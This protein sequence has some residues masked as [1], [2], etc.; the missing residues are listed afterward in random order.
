MPTPT[1][2]QVLA[3]LSAV[4]D[5]EIHQ[6]ITDLGM[7]DTVEVGA[8][9]RVRVVVLLTVPGARCATRSPGTS[10]RPWVRWRG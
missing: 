3:A 8:D 4:Q 6:P 2:E 1:V 7:V 9:G 10:R 5:P